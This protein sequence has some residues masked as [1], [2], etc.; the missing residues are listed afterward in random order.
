[1][2]Y[3]DLKDKPWTGEDGGPKEVS[4][5]EVVFPG[6][7]MQEL[8]PP[9]DEIPEEFKESDGTKWNVLFTKWFYHGVENLELFPKEGVDPNM[10]MRHIKA[11]MGSFE[12][13]QEHKE[14]GV[15]YL[16]SLWFDDIKYDISEK[17][18]E[19]P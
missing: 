3:K 9:Y 18:K 10:A 5:L 12:P 4:N 14:S 13:S 1:M 2:E 15:A 11:C 7:A 8:L 6:N 19:T 17:K 16:L